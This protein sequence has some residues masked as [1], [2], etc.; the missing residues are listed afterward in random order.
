M[1]SVTPLEANTFVTDIVITNS[2]GNDTLAL[3]LAKVIETNKTITAINLESN[4]IEEVGMQAL[5]EAV[6]KTKTLTEL[7]LTHQK[8]SI[9]TS[10][11]ESFVSG[12]ETN[13]VT[14]VCSLQIRDRSLDQRMNKALAANLDLRRRARHEMNRA[15][16]KGNTQT[17]S[18]IQVRINSLK[19]SEDKIFAVPD[20]IQ[21][22]QLNEEWKEQILCTN[23]AGSRV[24]I[25]D[26]SGCGLKDGFC[27]QLAALYGARL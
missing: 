9:A 6:Q 15:S 26:L 25:L 12:V 14:T 3:H 1:N 2:G 7:R 18:E 20:S 27:A 19:E 4:G 11:M 23:L 5:A 13:L 21:F 24:E 22:Q 8:K 16:G 17:L 10:A